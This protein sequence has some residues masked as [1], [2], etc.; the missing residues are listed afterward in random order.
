MLRADAVTVAAGAEA[1]VIGARRVAETFGGRAR[2][3]Q[4]ALIDGAP[5]LV[6]MVG[7]Q[8]K[9]V[10][11]FAIKDGKIVGIELLS[12]PVRL[13]GLDVQLLRTQRA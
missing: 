9:V 7:G 4:L 11:E 1:E 12:D 8:P 13:R 10:F 6:W 2:A 5:G 3:A